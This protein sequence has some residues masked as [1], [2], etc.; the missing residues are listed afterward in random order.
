MEKRNTT[1]IRPQIEVLVPY[2]W[3]KTLTEYLQMPFRP[4][5]TFH[6]GETALFPFIWAK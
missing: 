4:K 1:E 3:L 6:F 5:E 2:R